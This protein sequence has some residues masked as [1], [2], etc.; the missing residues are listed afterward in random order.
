MSPTGPG[1][2]R[3]EA[4]VTGGLERIRAGL[5]PLQ[6]RAFRGIARR[7]DLEGAGGPAYFLDP[8]AFPVIQLPTWCVHWADRRDPG[9]PHGAVADLQE[10]ALAGYLH[11]RVQDDLLDE[12]EG[13][14][15][16]SML[17]AEALLLR[18]LSLVQR[19][20]GGSRAFADLVERRWTDYGEAMLLEAEVHGGRVPLDDGVFQRVLDRSRP[21]VLPGAAALA[22]AGAEAELRILD[23]YVSA[24]AE[25]HQWFHDLGDAERDLREGRRTPVTE[26]Y[27]GDGDPAAMRQRLVT[28]GGYDQVVGEAR[29]ALER[30]AGLAREIGLAEAA[31][32]AERR[33]QA[34]DDAQ[35]VLYR[36]LF[37]AIL[38]K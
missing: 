37:E 34:M 29:R 28:G 22:A 20:A 3:W 6:D 38:E 33:I 24:L 5:G 23:R 9:L 8:R 7:L 16:P 1:G 12:G 13:E 4:A 11:V 17:L 14:A 25:G 2:D 18:H 30:A 27:G 32:D 35:Q 15:I 21:L 26:R 31:A 19:A 10:A 36:G